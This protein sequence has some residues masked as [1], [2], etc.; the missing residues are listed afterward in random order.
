[1][2]ECELVAELTRCGAIYLNGVVMGRAKDAMM[3]RLAKAANLWL[4][5]GSQAAKDFMAP[6]NAITADWKQ[7]NAECLARMGSGD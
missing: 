5:C 3:F 7:R 1:M 6:G 2:T 4:K